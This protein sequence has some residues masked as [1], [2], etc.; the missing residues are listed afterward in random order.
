MIR[1]WRKRVRTVW[2]QL[3]L[4]EPLMPGA[5]A[6]PVFER[7]DQEILGWSGP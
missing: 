1:A 4:A 5:G 7:K 3:R 2:Y 6:P